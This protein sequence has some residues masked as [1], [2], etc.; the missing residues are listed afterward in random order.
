MTHATSFLFSANESFSVTQRAM[1]QIIPP[2][3]EYQGFCLSLSSNKD[4]EPFCFSIA[5]G[6]KNNKS[7]EICKHCQNFLNSERNNTDRCNKEI[8]LNGRR[9]QAS[10]IEI[11]CFI[12]HMNGQWSLRETTLV[13]KSYIG[14]TLLMTSP[15]YPHYLHKGQDTYI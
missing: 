1:Q 10:L 12:F 11:M 14:P 5:A 3:N 7:A 6:S 13:Q 9:I 15:D 4:L 8:S 2:M